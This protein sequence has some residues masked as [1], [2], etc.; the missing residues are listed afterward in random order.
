MTRQMNV[1]VVLV[2]IV[3]SFTLNLLKTPED[4]PSPGDYAERVP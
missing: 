4:S 3:Y 1:F 2:I